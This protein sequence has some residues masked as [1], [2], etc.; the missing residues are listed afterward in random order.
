[1]AEQVLQIVINATDN[2]SRTLSSVGGAV[3]GF[4]AAV[5]TGLV[6]A[7]AAGV[8]A[9]AGIGAAAVGAAS[10]F[11]DATSAIVAGTG[12]T[13]GNLASMERIVRNLA[14]TTGGLNQTFGDLGAVVAEVN[15]RTGAVGPE[16]ETLSGQ[17][18][19]I[20]RL[21]G[22]DAVGNV[23]SLTRVF[24]DWA[25]AS[26]DQSAVLDTLFGATQTFGIGMDAVSRNV[27]QFGAP[28]RQMGFSLEESIALFGKWE[29]EGVNAEL[30][31]GS[32]RIAAGNFARDGVPL[33]EGLTDTMDAIRGTTDESEALAIA[34]DVFGARAGPDM[35]AAIREGRFELE[36]A[37]AALSGTEGA[38]ADASARA[39]TSGE[40]WQMFKNQLRAAIVP[41]GDVVLN[42]A[43]RIFPMLEKNVIPIVNS[44]VGAF[45]GFFS[46]LDSG[47]SAAESFRENFI[48]GLGESLGVSDERIG[49]LTTAFDSFVSTITG[50]VIPAITEFVGRVWEFAEPLVTAI[51]DFVS[52]K[53]VLIAL[54]IAV[55]AVVIPAIVSIVSS[56]LPIIAIGAA[57]I[58]AVAL[59]RTA[60]E[61]NFLGIRDVVANVISFVRGF[62]ENGIA[63]VSA[64]WTANGDQI[65]ATAARVWSNVQ[66]AVAGAIEFVRGVISGFVSAVNAFWAAHGEQIMN[67]IRGAWEFIQERIAVGVANIRD[68]VDAFRAAFEGDWRTFGEKLR[69]IWDRSWNFMVETLSNI[70][71]TIAT[72]VSTLIENVKNKFQTTD[73]GAVGRS[74]IDGIANGL[75]AAV[76]VIADA[77]AS[78]ASA[79]LDAAK[80]FLGIDSPSKEF[81]KL[82]EFSGDGLAGGIVAQTGAIRGAVVDA[83]SPAVDTARGLL[84][85]IAAPDLVAG[86]PGAN[87]SP[88]GFGLDG[89]ALGENGP[90]TVINNSFTLNTATAAPQSDVVADFD[91]MRSWAEF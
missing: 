85:G 55:A 79:A 21:T 33:R 11:Q 38:L 14:G 74:I 56:M 46:S 72:A 89:V 78:A 42:L 28:L 67:V 25:V 86:F 29:K 2:A 19:N 60:W 6:A 30:A 45:S 80:G 48:V 31:I 51:A 41:A 50:T 10:D 17:I 8:A 66:T 77:A 59:L 5:T 52:W 26:E 70:G 35:A 87:L 49:Q 7:G 43:E 68:V 16:L 13:G 58:G 90:R 65:L 63:A 22:S 20:S 71:E 91:L 40:R 88:A 32:L 39:V 3:S 62:I 34:M 81:F 64:F 1:M 53:D 69:E 18:L 37:I 36:G 73:W 61:T 84:T 44:V 12:A 57:I 4:G 83:I 82:G 9:A 54:G 23:Q 27:V 47:A 76:G 75:T 24:G 15:T